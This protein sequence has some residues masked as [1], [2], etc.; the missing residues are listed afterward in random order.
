[1]NNTMKQL[2]RTYCSKNN[3]K[4][5]PCTLGDYNAY[6]GWKIPDNE[7]P[8]TE[9]YVIEYFDGHESWLPKT[10]F[11]LLYKEFT[12]LN[13]GQAIEALKEGGLVCRKGWNGKGMFIF[14]RPSDSLNYDFIIN[15][16]KSLPNTLKNHY[17]GI[18]QSGVNEE[19][20]ENLLQTDVKFTSYL[21]MLAADGT[22]VNGWLAS[23][24]D[25]LAEDWCILE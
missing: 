11:E 13:F 10:S 18:V 24:T 19:T 6:R 9:G 8:E 15:K 23:Q 5:S 22:I 17:N 25:M 2:A 7:K 1:M 20:K 16:V 14:M 3:L 4:A 12:N 21:C